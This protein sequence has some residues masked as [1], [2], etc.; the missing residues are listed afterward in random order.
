MT[1]YKSVIL[2]VGTNKR[3]SKEPEEVAAKMV[4]LIKDLK[5]NT[6]KIAV[7]NVTKRYDNR[8]PARKIT[9]FNYNPFKYNPPGLQAILRN[10]KFLN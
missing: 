1:K 7:S 8:V 3:V 6:R 5:G 4:G 9:P 2:Y 10:I